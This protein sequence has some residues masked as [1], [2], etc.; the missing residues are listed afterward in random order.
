MI[1]LLSSYYAVM[2]Q[3]EVGLVTARGYRGAKARPASARQL[4]HELLIPKIARLHAESYCVYRVRKMRA[5]LR[6]QGWAIG[7][8]QRPADADR[9]CSRGGAV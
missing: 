5:L 4:R 6:R 1:D 8:D 9:W 3:A 7:R 2:R